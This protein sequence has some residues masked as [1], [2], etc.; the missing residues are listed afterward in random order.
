MNSKTEHHGPDEGQP[1]EEMA[2]IGHP[3]PLEPAAFARRL[4]EIIKRALRGA[5][6]TEKIK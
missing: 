6:R 3:P 5:R 1:D 4:A 2:A